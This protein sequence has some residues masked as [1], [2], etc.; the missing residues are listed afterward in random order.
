VAGALSTRILLRMARGTEHASPTPS[1][2]LRGLVD[3]LADAG[4]CAERSPNTAPGRFRSSAASVPDAP[5]GVVYIDTSALVKLVV[6]QP[7]ATR[8]NMRFQTFLAPSAITS[9]ELARAVARAR[10]ERTV[11]IA[12]HN[13][14]FTLLAALAEVPSTSRSAPQACVRPPSR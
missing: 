2:T 7:G 3:V 1:P 6:S 5:Q 4:R 12:D 8:S 9:V 10:A 13:A 11:E 14:I